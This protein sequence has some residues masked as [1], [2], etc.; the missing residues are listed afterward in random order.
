M[1][2]KNKGPC[3]KIIHLGFV[4]CDGG[5]VG[6]L[7]GQMY[8]GHGVP[9]MDGLKNKKTRANTLEVLTTGFGSYD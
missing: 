2:W 8:F 3:V 5:I 1:I 7:L 4:L 9:P 6:K